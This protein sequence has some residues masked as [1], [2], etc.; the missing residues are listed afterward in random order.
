MFEFGTWVVPQ[1]VT[2]V[3]PCSRVSTAFPH[4]QWGACEH[5]RFVNVIYISLRTILGLIVKRKMVES[6]WKDFA[7]LCMVVVWG[8]VY[9]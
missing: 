7:L 8:S 3:S 5:S 4:F 2:A 6:K 9:F 1:L